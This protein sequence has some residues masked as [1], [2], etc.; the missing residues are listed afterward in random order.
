MDKELSFHN[1]TWANS[2]FVWW[3]PVI[4]SYH[5]VLVIFGICNLRWVSKY[6][7]RSV[8]VVPRAECFID[9]SMH[10]RVPEPI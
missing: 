6:Y 10:L 9:A 2:R 8:S 4:N 5:T 7:H 3:L 1:D